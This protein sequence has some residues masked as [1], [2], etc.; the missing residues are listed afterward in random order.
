MTNNQHP[1]PAI[2]QA[3]EFW[4]TK[5]L[6][7][8]S[9]LEW[10]SICDGCGKCC[11]QQLE[12]DDTGELVF[13]DVACDLLEAGSCRC[14]DYPN[15]S[16]RVPTCMT[17]TKQNVAQCAEFAPPTCAYRLLLQNEELPE[18]HHLRCGDRNRIHTAGHSVA[19][20][21]RKLSAVDVAKL[22]D[23]VVEWP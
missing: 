6:F 5:S 9:R 21:T 22:E 23:Y 16:V 8:M 14:T 15:R 12:D 20:K 17:M 11:L 7:E 18:W 19:G 2:D 4:K 10:E 13:T 1:E 3:S